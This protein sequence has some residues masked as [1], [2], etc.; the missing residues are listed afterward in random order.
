VSGDRTDGLPGR[1]LIVSSVPGRQGKWLCTVNGPVVH[2]L[3]KFR[4]ADAVEEFFKWVAENEGR[5]LELG[6]R[7]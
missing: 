4:D 1:E 5:R 6:D 3:A 2:S 7:V